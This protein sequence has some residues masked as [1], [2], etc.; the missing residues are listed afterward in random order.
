MSNSKRIAKNTLFLYL[1]SFFVLLISLYTSRVILRVLGVEDYGIY[2]VVGGVISMVG[3]LKG[4]LQSTYQRYYNVEMGRGNEDGVKKLF[5]SSLSTQYILAAIILFLAETIGLWFVI[6]KLVIPS[7]RMGAAL[8]IYQVAVVSF[9]L[10]AF[11]SP[12]VAA[13]TA[14]E[15]MGVF[16]FISVIDAVLRLGIVF[17]IEWLPGDHLIVYAILLLCIAILNFLMYVIYCM[18]RIPTVS[19]LPCWDKK[20]LL[21]LFSFS[22]WTIINTL[23]QTLKTQGL[24]IVLNLFFG[25]V[26]NAARGI[27]AQILHAVNQFITSFQTSF[28]PQLTKSYASGDYAYMKKLYHSATKLSYFLIFTLSLPILLETPVILDLWLGD[29]VPEHTIAFTRLVLITAFVSSFANPTSCIVYATGR[30]KWFSIMVSGLNLLIVPLAYLFLWLGYEPESALVVS[31]VMTVFVHF[32]RM[33]LVSRMTVLSLQDY[34]SAVI[35][36]LGLYTFTATLLPFV[37][38]KLMDAN[39]YR[40]LITIP[41]AVFSSLISMWLLAMNAAEKDMFRNLVIKKIKKR[42][43]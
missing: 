42:F 24:N 21:S 15:R 9:L 13:I 3:F 14:Y 25:P 12:F 31:L 39:W 8:W 41:G 35:L 18:K 37:I 36:P 10:T 30:I 5:R 26:V 43:K 38:I 23:A 2:N 20:T 4:N 34:F 17:T 11:S 6:H 19:L 27:S 22:G 7:D 28:R 16:A 33:I 29:R 32:V 40:L 1:R